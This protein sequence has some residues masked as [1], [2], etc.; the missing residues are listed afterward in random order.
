[1][2]SSRIKERCGNLTS[3]I[4]S[5]KVKTDCQRK[6]DNH[7][8]LV[9]FTFGEILEVLMPSILTHILFDVNGK[10]LLNRDTLDNCC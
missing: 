4:M 6:K 1:M 8:P 9:K 10:E 2:N 3:A 5:D 7:Q